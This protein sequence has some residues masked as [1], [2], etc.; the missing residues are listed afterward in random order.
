MKTITATVLSLL[1]TLQMM[2]G[3]VIKNPEI[4]YTASWMKITEIE[5]TKEATIVRGTLF[6]GSSIVNNTVL[7]DRNS[8][9]EFKFIRV[10]GINA[11]EPASEET[12]YAV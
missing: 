11:Y 9:K 7:K 12:A 1:I 10:E 2:A 6:N 8:G 5:L 4:E 3:K